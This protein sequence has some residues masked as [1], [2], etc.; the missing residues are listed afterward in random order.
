MGWHGIGGR[1]ESGGATNSDPGH[2]F[3]FRKEGESSV[4]ECP[5]PP[6]P[7][8]CLCEGRDAGWAGGRRGEGKRVAALPVMIGKADMYIFIYMCVCECACVQCVFKV[9]KMFPPPLKCTVSPRSSVTL[10]L[11]QPSHCSKLFVKGLRSW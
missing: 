7:L 10:V 4:P 11:A 9:G 6:V 3:P 1:G 2:R 8:T 5:F